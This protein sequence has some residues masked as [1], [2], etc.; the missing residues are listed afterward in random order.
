MDYPHLRWFNRPPP[1]INMCVTPANRHLS[2]I[3]TRPTPSL[4]PK[5]PF[6]EASLCVVRNSAAAPP[7]L[8]MTLNDVK[9]L[10]VKQLPNM[11]A[12]YVTRLVYDFEAES[13]IVLHNG[14]VGAAISSRLF[15]AQG[16]IEIVFCAVESSL[17]S[18]GYGRLA[19][20][21]LKHVI[22]TRGI[23][24]I[25]TCADNDAVG[26]FKKQGFNPVEIR[27]DPERWVGYIKDY[28]LVTLVHC[29]L[30]PEINYMTFS[31]HALAQQLRFLSQRTGL[32][33]AGPI[34][35][36]GEDLPA[37]PH[38]VVNVSLP[39]PLILKR[40]A[41]D[42]QTEGV[43]KLL[44]GYEKR[45]KTV[46]EKLFRILDGLKA[47]VKNSAIFLRPVTE[48]VAADY[49]DVIG[50]PMDLFSIENRLR[51]YVDYYKRPDIFATDVTL[52]CDNAKLFN[53]PDS[54]FYKNA[55]ELFKRFKRLYAEEFPEGSW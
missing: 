17:Q 48:D 8:L 38:A 51:R 21:Y 5:D 33:V 32:R 31:T 2:K 37:L 44:T 15:P 19:M 12:S 28:D 52:M 42:L 18:R 10:F 24:D 41:K 43:R 40:Y 34:P 3:Y 23:F 25:L 45:C 27:M 4:R 20:M 49:F 36:F 9:N 16:F 29:R 14:Q 1:H 30:H 53:P 6:H 13:V 39:I 50:S 26:Y 22:Q 11:G 55:V 54:P 46:R 47:D 35:E 7:Q